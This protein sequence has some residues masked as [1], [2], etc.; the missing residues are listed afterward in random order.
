MA[1]PG[2][3]KGS[4]AGGN[5]AAQAGAET[6]AG[7]FRNIFMENPKLLKTRSN[8]EL[9][10]RWLDDHPGETEVPDRV[11][12]GLANAKSALRKKLRI[13]GRRRKAAGAVVVAGAPAK[14][15]RPPGSSS[16]RLEALEEHID[17]CL[18]HAKNVDREGLDDIIKL[19]RRARNL[20]VWKIGQ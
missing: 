16:H 3:K 2:R 4:G 12:I 11:K 7:Y 10:R 18:T 15:G 17:D 9:I 19:L 6:S 8:E 13:R 1:R 14:I 20:V 5:S